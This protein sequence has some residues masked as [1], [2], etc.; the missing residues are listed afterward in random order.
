MEIVV[1]AHLC[2]SL[3][4]RLA[5]HQGALLVADPDTRNAI[6]ERN[7]TALRDQLSA[8][9]YFLPKHAKATMEH[10]HAITEALEHAPIAIAIGSGS[11]N[12]IV[13]YAAF[14]HNLPYIVIPTAPSMNGY[15]S[16]T[17]SLIEQHRK[18]SFEA[19]APMAVYA[20]M[21]ILAAAPKRMIAAGVGDVLCRG[22]VE[23]DWRLAHLKKKVAYDDSLM[24]PL[25][26]TEWELIHNIDGIEQRDEGVIGLLWEAL[27]T[28]GNAMRL[29]GSSMP[30]SQGE[31]MIAHAMEARHGSTSHLHGEEI[32]VTTLT[33]SRLQHRLLPGI[34][35]E[36]EWIGENMHDTE[37]L[38]KTLKKA[39]CPLTPEA[40]GWNRETYR[41]IANTAWKTRDRYGFLALAAEQN[42]SVV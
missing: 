14:R 3:P 17:A 28:G 12:D 41:K 34:G 21:N 4:E 26:G 33:M 7:F 5:D 32:A 16:S 2:K 6:G 31:H 27:L 11:I 13:K 24:A 42:V 15:T 40:L 39:G 25:R 36:A 20:D 1:S 18:H 9:T 29:H 23:A 30:A 35:K 19:A 37:L 10:A 38:E 8:R 22:T